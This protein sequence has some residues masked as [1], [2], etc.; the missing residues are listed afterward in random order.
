LVSPPTL[1]ETGVIGE[2]VD[3]HWAG[4]RHV[5]IGQA[6]AWYYPAERLLVLWERYLF[7]HWRLADPVRDPAL[8]GL[9][10]R[11]EAELLARFPEAERLA[12]PSW[13]DMYERPA[14]Q[15]F[16]RQQG[17]APATTG[18]FVKTS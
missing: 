11:F 7:D 13:E 18:A 10:Q 17:Y 9:W 16:L 3:S 5:E 14:W 6:Q 1:P 2:I 15:T 12:T 8:H 4:M